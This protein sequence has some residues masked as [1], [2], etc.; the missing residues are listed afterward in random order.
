MGSGGAGC[1]LAGGK[2]RWPTGIAGSQPRPPKSLLRGGGAGNGNAANNGKPGR[3]SCQFNKGESN[4]A[5]R[6]YSGI[7][8]PGQRTFEQYRREYPGTPENCLT[9]CTV[10]IVPGKKYTKVD[11]GTSGK[12]MINEAGTIF[13]IKG[14]GVIH[15]GHVYGTLNTIN[16]WNWGGYT[17][18]PK[19]A[20]QKLTQVKEEVAATGKPQATVSKEMADFFGMKEEFPDS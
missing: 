3:W 10:K 17:G 16:G 7:R 15:R 8:S 13:G 14:Y 4:V 18:T 2:D 6:E 5:S 19:T 20:A 12:Y 1:G 11:V 9:N